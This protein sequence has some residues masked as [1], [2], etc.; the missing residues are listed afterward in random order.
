VSVTSSEWYILVL[1][2]GR[3]NVEK[4][5]DL[6]PEPW[7]SPSAQGQERKREAMTS[8]EGGGQGVRETRWGRQREPQVLSWAEN[9]PYNLAIQCH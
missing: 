7:D 1:R 9:G 2:A 5:K 3:E 4:G 6:S 8:K